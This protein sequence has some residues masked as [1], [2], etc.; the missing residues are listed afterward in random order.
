MADQIV[1]ICRFSFLGKGDWIGM[2]GSNVIDADALARQAAILYAPERLARRMRAFETMFLPWISAQTDQDFALWILTS[3]E[4]P[5]DTRA[6]LQ[7]LCA[8]LAQV[9]IITSDLRVT[10][11]ALSAPLAKAA[12]RQDGRPVMQFRIDDD[13]TL[14]RHYIARLRAQMRRFDD[15]GAVA[16]SMP[17]GIILRSYG[18]EPLSYWRLNQSFG[19]A[20]AAA[21]LWM[22]N[23]SIYS[24]NH[25]AL[26]RALPSFCEP[27]EPGYVQIRW[28]MGD[29][30]VPAQENWGPHYNQISR[31]AYEAM[32]ADDFPWLADADLGFITGAS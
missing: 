5:A 13:D 3:P 25:F 4:L 26:P 7:E 10:D 16:I 30:A 15:L 22:A 6:R 17:L 27:R 24:R 23:R 2:R 12:A 28:N 8:G 21:R 29:S 32:I 11:D 18:T 20:G 19:S 1:G 9:R 14:S 31:E